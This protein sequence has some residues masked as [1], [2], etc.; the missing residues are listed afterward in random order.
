[1]HQPQ[2]KPHTPHL[3]PNLWAQSAPVGAGQEGLTQ[4]HNLGPVLPVGRGCAPRQGSGVEGLPC[5][6]ADLSCLPFQPRSPCHPP[7]HHHPRRGSGRR[8]SRSCS[9]STPLV[10]PSRRLKKPMTCNELINEPHEQLSSPDSPSCCFWGGLSEAEVPSITSSLCQRGLAVRT[11]V[12]TPAHAFGQRPQDQF[13]RDQ[14]W[15]GNSG[16]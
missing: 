10:S 3:C 8:R 16:L 2:G 11:R 1:M 6:R 12:P 5:S 4:T 9:G 13:R 7:G 15:S 14:F